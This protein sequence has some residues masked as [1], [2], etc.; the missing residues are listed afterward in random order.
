[1]PGISGALE[2]S[3]QNIIHPAQFD[4]LDPVQITHS[5]ILLLVRRNDM[6]GGNIEGPVFAEEDCPFRPEEVGSDGIHRN[7]IGSY[8]QTFV[9]PNVPFREAIQK[10]V[11][12]PER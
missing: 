5:E 11:G 4:Q 6:D 8:D 2:S 10:D 3:D 7:R 12:R 1:L 9:R